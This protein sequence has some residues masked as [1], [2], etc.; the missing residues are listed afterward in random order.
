MTFNVGIIGL[1]MIG[2]SMLQ[3]FL[4]HPAFSVGGVWDRNEEI[5]RQI[6]GQF[7]DVQI[8]KNAASMIHDPSIDLIYIATPPMTHVDYAHQVIGAGKALLC[9]K[10]LAIDLEQGRRLVVAAEEQQVPTAM[11]FVYGA[12]S[13]VETLEQQLKSGAIGIPQSIEVRYQFPSWPCLLY[14]SPS[15]RDS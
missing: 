1:G 2:A 15:P 11:N 4:T 13:V 14:T 6:A 3:E 10:P 8:A 9:D 5:N 7:P 12:G